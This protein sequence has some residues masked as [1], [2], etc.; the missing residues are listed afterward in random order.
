MPLQGRVVRLE[1]GLDLVTPKSLVKPGSF[2]DC[3]NYEF[4]DEAGPRRT[5]G[6]RPF[7]N[8]FR[9]EEEEVYYLTSTSVSTVINASVLDAVG[10]I[11]YLVGSGKTIPFGILFAAWAGSGNTKYIAYVRINSD[12]EPAIG[13]NVVI[14][15][16][17]TAYFNFV[18]T[19][20]KPKVLSKSGITNFASG[21]TQSY[22]A[23]AIFSANNMASYWAQFNKLTNRSGGA[24][25]NGPYALRLDTSLGSGVYS[26]G[27]CAVPGVTMFGDKPYAVVDTRRMIVSNTGSVK[28]LFPGDKIYNA[29]GG[30][31][32]NYV[33]VVTKVT[34]TAGNWNNVGGVTATIEVIEATNLERY[35]AADAKF[36]APFASGSF[37]G[38]TMRL[39]RD[40]A[41][42]Y[43][44]ADIS[45]TT[46]PS[47]DTATLMRAYSERQAASA[48]ELAY[49][50]ITNSTTVPY[51]TPPVVQIAG[52]GGYGATAEAVIDVAGTLSSIH[53]TNRGWGYTSAPTVTVSGGGGTYTG[54]ITAFLYDYRHAGWREINTGWIV[55]F[56]NGDSQSDFLTKV[57]R[58]RGATQQSTAYTST[59]YT[60]TP[61]FV[62]TGLDYNGAVTQSAAGGWSSTTNPW[63]T[64]VTAIDADSIGW[65]V[66]ALNFTS[67]GS[68]QSL[69]FTNFNGIQNTLPENAVIQGITCKVYWVTSGAGFGTSST[70]NIPT[71]K[72]RCALFKTSANADDPS[73]RTEERLGNIEEV[74]I[75]PSIVN[76]SSQTTTFGGSANLWGTAIKYSD[77][78]DPRFGFAFDIY[79]T[80][81]GGFSWAD[82]EWAIDKIE[83][84]VQYQD[85]TIRYYFADGAGNVIAADLVDYALT[86]GSF[87]S[88][89]AKGYFQIGNLTQ[90]ATTSSVATAVHTIKS[91]WSM[92]ASSTLSA[93]SKVADIT[94]TM[95]YN[96]LDGSAR[97]IAA[98][99]RYQFEQA[100]FYASEDWDSIYGVSGAGR[101]FQF[102]GK[103]FQRIYAYNPSQADSATLDKPRHVAKHR[104]RLALGYKTGLV[105]FSVEGA[106]TNFDG[107]F[108]AA[109]V[110]VGDRITGFSQGQGTYLYV[111]GEGSVTGIR[112]S[113]LNTTTVVPAAG[114]IEYTVQN[115]GDRTLFCN[116]RGI[117]ALDQSQK[118]GDFEGT[119][120]SYPVSS[121]L[122][123]RLA[124]QGASIADSAASGIVCAYVV[125]AKNQYIVWFRDGMQLVMTL[126]GPEQNTVFTFKK[127]FFPGPSTTYLT[128]RLFPMALCSKVDSN[129]KE[130]VLFSLDLIR[131]VAETG[132]LTVPNTL[133]SYVY[134]GETGWT[135]SHPSFSGSIPA[136][137]VTNHVFGENPFLKWTLKK[138]RVEGQSR[139]C[140]DL[141]M[142]ISHDYA[143]PEDDPTVARS[144]DYNLP[145]TEQLGL[146]VNYTAT[147]DMVNIRDTGRL[148]NLRSAHFNNSDKH[149][150]G[151]L[152]DDSPLY[153]SNVPQPSHYVQLLLIQYEE[154]G[155]DA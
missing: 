65:G 60:T 131:G 72:M 109:E 50:T 36:K 140:A 54:T 119:R 90:Y 28:E 116:E 55:P 118:Y 86:G 87:R 48:G 92:Y 78:I 37:N 76:G 148:V 21:Y 139:G 138:V 31:I 89:D 23:E 62:M 91:G 147:S 142:T 63:A 152:N 35:V 13:D 8:S 58:G 69:G 25:Y 151:S 10:G 130:R 133:T 112:D 136:W 121:W 80:R 144:V 68:S 149:N 108:G 53:I 83:I 5:D 19:T 57:D 96:S 134:E 20:A 111:F 79:L 46:M 150:Y 61:R 100:N 104:Y 114:A 7:D 52:G 18:S 93:G 135:Y 44:V 4:V 97:V 17:T 107:I 14:H 113:D 126:V 123:S 145:P 146:P 129:G 117:S 34:K 66:R 29:L 22:P 137:F 1:G 153:G 16:S 49:I 99:S 64:A 105:D 141:N 94:D 122:R 51:T 30:S 74:A 132:A 81:A 15:S 127:Y 43:T 75:A 77:I 3:L 73:I 11:H 32:P 71:C 120:L 128:G 27:V 33:F 12:Q 47:N 155:M 39:T 115:I 124:K 45:E 101:A 67:S 24:A 9:Y 70:S 26:K 88:K 82:F 38:L 6:Y 143:L 41:Q 85:P 106:P 95:E 98:E 42:T 103:Y 110:G 102:D 2:L 40:P 84:T 59:S 56:Q 125:R 154:G